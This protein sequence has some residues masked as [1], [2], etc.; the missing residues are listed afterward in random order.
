MYVSIRAKC[1]ISSGSYWSLETGE[2]LLEPA[3]LVLEIRLEPIEEH[4][5]V[6]QIAVFLDVALRLAAEAAC[7]QVVRL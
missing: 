1:T 5:D 2:H 3:P 6:V 7:A 4:R